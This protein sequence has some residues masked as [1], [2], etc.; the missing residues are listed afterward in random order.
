[1]SGVIFFISF[2]KNIESLANIFCA[3]LFTAEVLSSPSTDT[4]EYLNLVVNSGKTPRVSLMF[5]LKDQSD[6]QEIEAGDW[7]ET[8]NMGELSIN[9]DYKVHKEYADAQRMAV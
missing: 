3:I 9:K 4:I 1:M 6:L 5:S 7:N 2:L 8:N